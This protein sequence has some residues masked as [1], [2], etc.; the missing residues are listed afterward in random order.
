MNGDEGRT[1]SGCYVHGAAV[2]G[3][4]QIDSLQKGRELYEVRLACEVEDVFVRT[5]D[6]TF[7]QWS[8]TRCAC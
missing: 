1:D 7:N 5:A 2:S 3:D 4:K 8:V 6:H